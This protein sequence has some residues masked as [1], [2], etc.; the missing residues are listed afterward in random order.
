MASH[1]AP[2]GAVARVGPVYTPLA[3]RRRVFGTAVTADASGA[4]LAGGATDVVLYTDLSNPI[5]PSIDY[6]PDHDA[7]ERTFL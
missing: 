6:R 7:D 3:L 4:A 2:A 5:Y 1:S